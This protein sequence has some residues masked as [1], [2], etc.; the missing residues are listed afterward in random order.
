MPR[1]RGSKN[2]VKSAVNPADLAT[3]ISE[4]ASVK[5]SLTAEV[6]TL[7]A[8]LKDKTAMLKSVTKE[9]AKLEDQKIKADAAEA[10]KAKKAEVEELI[11]KLLTD[12]ISAAEILEKLK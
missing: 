6:A 3:L 5:E 8:E 11:E 9:L 10:E 1:P 7:R 2:K 12:G 4:K